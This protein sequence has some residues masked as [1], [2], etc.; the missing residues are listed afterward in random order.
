MTTPALK[1]KKLISENILQFTNWTWHN[2]CIAYKIYINIHFN[3]TQ[4]VVDKGGKEAK[5]NTVD[6]TYINKSF[7]VFFFLQRR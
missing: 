3:Y 7:F 1:E 2:I 4:C 5:Q 6:V